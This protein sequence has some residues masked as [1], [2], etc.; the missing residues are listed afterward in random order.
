MNAVYLGDKPTKTGA[1]VNADE[2]PLL[3]SQDLSS[4]RKKVKKVTAANLK[5]SIGGVQS[6]QAGA[7]VSVD[8]TDP[9][10]PVV[11]ASGEVSISA[12]NGI[13]VTNNDGE[14]NFS[15]TR[16]VISVNQSGTDDPVA[17]EIQGGEAALSTRRIDVG[18]YEVT[19]SASYSNPILALL[20]NANEGL[21]HVSISGNTLLIKS[22]DLTLA[23]S[24]DILLNCQIQIEEI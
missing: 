1:V 18:E 14:F 13:Q 12:S 20:S 7:N 4:G 3:D 23:L 11:S 6:V 17:S 19:L 9:A 15:L 2:I 10:N 22:R 8:N 24:D 21:V 16:I 5:E